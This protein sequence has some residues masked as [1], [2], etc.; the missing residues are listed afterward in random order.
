VRQL[1]TMHHETPL[2]VGK[3]LI[4]P[5]AQVTGT[6]AYGSSVS[7]R[8]GGGRATHDRIFRFV[9]RFDTHEAACRYATEQ[10][11]LWLEQSA[12]AHVH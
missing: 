9:A 6:S 10:G 11:L 3:Y 8:S 4:S 7:I 1:L 12:H 2:S 5:L